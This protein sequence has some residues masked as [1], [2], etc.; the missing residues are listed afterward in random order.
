MLE[1]SQVKLPEDKAH[2]RELFWEYLQWANS[3][4]NEEFVSV[5]SYS[6][7]STGPNRWFA[8]TRFC[9]VSGSEWCETSDYGCDHDP[10]VGHFAMQ[11]DHGPSGEELMTL[12][13]F[14][15]CQCWNVFKTQLSSTLQK[16][17]GNSA[18]AFLDA[19]KSA[20]ATWNQTP[21]ADFTLDFAGTMQS[22]QAGY[23]HVNE[24]VFMAKGVDNRGALAQVW[25]TGDGTIV[26]ADIWINDDFRWVVGDNLPGDEVDLQSALL[27]E[28][29][30]W[31]ILNHTSDP[32]SVMFPTLAPGASKRQLS[33]WEVEGI[34]AIYPCL[35]DACL[36]GH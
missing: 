26:E 14:S 31:L 7:P 25:Y 15:S 33:R 5:T 19:I 28:F 29:G 32:H 17:V 11:L 10:N 34:S 8:Y 22:T 2:V 21:S 27:H 13:L 20:A 30:H 23:N 18:D 36:F 6:P 35:Q 9:R 12:T 3:K 1:I 4:T 16:G 24:I